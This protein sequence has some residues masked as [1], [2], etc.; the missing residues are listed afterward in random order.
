[1]KMV[2]NIAIV[3]FSASFMFAGIGFHMAN[4]YTG[5]DDAL[6]ATITSSWGATYDLNGTTSVGFDSELGMMMYFAAPAGA[7]LRLG[8]TPAI[9]AGDGTSVDD[10]ATSTSLGLGYT[11]W[12]GGDGVKTS[13]TTNF[14]YVMAP[15]S[16]D[17]DIQKTNTS[18]LSIVVGFGF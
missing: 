5:L 17:E 13:L 2:K 18:N 1:M 3:A 9:G 4:N 15:S 11:W 14:D 8:W 12:T 6:G 10:L 7:T 16:A